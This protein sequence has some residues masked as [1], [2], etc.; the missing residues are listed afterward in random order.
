MNPLRLVVFLIFLCGTSLFAQFDIGIVLP[1][2]NDTRDAQLDWIGE[3][4]VEVLSSDLA[5]S[6]FMMLDRRERTAAFDSLGLPS[7][8]ILSDAT[9]YKVAQALDV[10]KL[11]QGHYEYSN[12]VFTARARVLDMEGP[13]LSKEFTESGPLA[14]LIQLQTGLAWQIMRYLRPGLPFSKSD[15][16][17]SHP[18]PRLEAFENY[19][20]GLISR[21]RAD[22]I[23]YFRNA[24]RLDPEFTNPAFEL[25]MIYFHD[26]DYPTAV[27]W[28]SK[29]RRGDPEY[30]DANYFLGL[31]FLYQEQYERS[32]A[33]FRVVLQQ[34]PLNEVYNNLGIA[35]IR[36]D[37]PGAIGYFEK[38]SQSDPSDPVYQFNYGYALWKRDSCAQ[39]IPHLRKAVQ[40]QTN[41]PAWRAVYMQCLKTTGQAEEAVRQEKL[42]QQQ[43]AS[44]WAMAKDT[45][46]QNLERPKDNYDGASLRQLRMLIQVQTELKHAK[47]PLQEHV[48]LHVQQGR[49][50]LEEGYDR[51]AAE[52]FQQAIDYD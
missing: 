30:L 44:E 37:R 52:Q 41:R 15:F 22:Q 45:K 18:G 11:V 51:E 19:L 47:L 17:S 43:G 1:F 35:L 2:E 28:L 10:N 32:A 8:S 29:L 24:L 25:G 9:I 21:G 14:S 16:I 4:F 34:L 38:A 50:L 12:G 7:T 40:G 31:A 5:S 39:A 23:R 26:R 13:H 36:Q 48:A 42:L 6:R 20:R 27:L 3:S 33:A 49:T 46:L